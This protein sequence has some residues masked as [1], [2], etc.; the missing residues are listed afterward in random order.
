MNIVFYL[1][2][3]SLF[4]GDEEL[5]EWE[6]NGFHSLTMMQQVVGAEVGQK[7]GSCHSQHRG[8]VDV[9]EILEV[10]KMHLPVQVEKFGI[11]PRSKWT[12]RLSK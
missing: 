8:I 4:C 5:F 2:Y 11:L 1:I 9:V 12:E 3:L 6:L 10:M 7:A